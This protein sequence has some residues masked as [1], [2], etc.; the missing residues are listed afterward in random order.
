MRATRLVHL[1]RLHVIT[2]INLCLKER[3]KQSTTSPPPHIHA[4]FQILLLLILSL[5][6]NILLSAAFYLFTIRLSFFRLD[7]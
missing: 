2:V 3:I 6:P 4:I 5:N 1:T 7:L